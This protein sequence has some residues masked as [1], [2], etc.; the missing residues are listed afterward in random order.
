VKQPYV[1][2]LGGGP[3]GMIYVGVTADLLARI[4]QH[5]TGSTGFAPRHRAIRLVRYE[6]LVDMATVIAREKQLKR[7][8][9]DWKISLVMSE[10][11]DWHD[12]APALGSEPVPFHR[13]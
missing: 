10:N 13:Q 11:P 7:W 8:H 9:R 4:Y 1:Y 2:I 3:L 6:F 5:R 12:L